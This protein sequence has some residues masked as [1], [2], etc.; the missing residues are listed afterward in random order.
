MPYFPL[1]SFAPD[2]EPTTPGVLKDMDGFLPTKRG[3][4]GLPSGEATAVTDALTATAIS[5]ISI[6]KVDGTVRTFAGTPTGLHEIVGTAWT[7]R[8]KSGGYNDLVDNRWVFTQL[9]NVTYAASKA[10]TLQKSSTAAFDDETAAPKCS[11]IMTFGNFNLGTFLMALD[12][13]DGTDTPDGWHTSAIGDGTDWTPSISTLSANGRLTSTPGPLI[14]GH[15]LG[16][17]AVAFKQHSIYLGRFMGPP[18]VVEWSLISEEIG[19]PAHHA[20]VN[21]GDRLL[22]P[23]TGTGNFYVYDSARL[24]PIPNELK[25]WFFDEQL[26][27]DFE[28][29]ITG[30]V[31]RKKGR[32]VWLFPSKDSTGGV[33]DKYISFQFEGPTPRWSS[34]LISA[35]L[36]MEF[37]TGSTIYNDLGADFTTYHDLPTNSYERAFV[38]PV[39]TDLAKITAD[40]KLETMTGTPGASSMTL[41]DIGING[42]TEDNVGDG[43]IVQLDSIRPRFRHNPAQSSAVASTRDDLG[44]DLNSGAEILALTYGRFDVLKSARWHSDRMDFSGSVEIMGTHIDWRGD[45]ED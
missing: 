30:I 39:S 24:A 26:D 28:S 17:D 8:S 40:D 2:A 6:Q 16:D 10:N 33:L 12:F 3:F 1:T 15:P 43:A 37:R 35:R 31:D 44:D 32:V 27:A 14:A 20:V 42:L 7:E 45:G 34:G 21:T 19:T 13:D 29:L 5:A 36:L 4:D 11:V 25:E 23:D 41:W 9:G 18:T 22:F 38:K